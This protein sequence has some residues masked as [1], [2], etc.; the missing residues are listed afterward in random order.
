MAEVM[1]NPELQADS[2]DDSQQAVV[3]KYGMRQVP[4]LT[5]F[6]VETFGGIVL[7]GILF[8]VALFIVLACTAGAAR[9]FLAFISFL[10][11]SAPASAGGL[12]LSAVTGLV[13]LTLMGLF[14]WSMGMPL[15]PTTMASVAGGM[16]GFLASLVLLGAIGSSW[17]F[18]VAVI[19]MVFGQLGASWSANQIVDRL[20][21]CMPE[22]SRDEIQSHISVFDDELND[23]QFGIRQIFVFTLW[24]AVAFAFL[25]FAG[26]QAP[27]AFTLFG[28]WL[29]AQVV[30]LIAELE[31]RRRYE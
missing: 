30:S 8:A 28:V 13:A 10:L 29:F 19:A 3:A 5:G 7:G 25:K 11:M 14:N 16:A 20:E 31:W 9:G 2:L 24:T 27:R 12:L 18:L 1:L 17:F 6:C 21:R 26:T 4:S 15:R 22:M 23:F